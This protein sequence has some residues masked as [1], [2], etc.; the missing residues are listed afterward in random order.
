MPE[1]VFFSGTMD[2]G[3]ST[4]ALQ[5]QHNRSARGLQGM[6]YTRDDREGEGKLSS[7]LGLATEAIEVADDLDFYTHVVQALTAGGRVDYVIA[8]EAQFLTP[9]QIDQLARVVDDL[10]VDV[11]AFGITTDFRSKLF[12]GSQRLVELADRVEVLQVEALCWCGARATHNAR[13]VGGQ[14]VVEGAQVVVGD[15]NRPGNEVG[16]EVLCR[17][18]HRRRMTAAR[19]R[20]AALSP[21]VLPVD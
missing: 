10:E 11:F 18:H 2:C 4:L 3:K 7:R 1:L 21:E 5:I 20:A 17:R 6:I 14:M 19:A 9:P 16:Y 8:D 12:P 15:V 13:T